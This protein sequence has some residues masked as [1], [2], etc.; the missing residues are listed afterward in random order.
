M[1]RRF[2][3]GEPEPRRPDDV[4]R[5]GP[6]EDPADFK[7]EEAHERRILSWSP[8]PDEDLGPEIDEPADDDPRLED[9]RLEDPR[10]KDEVREQARAVAEPRAE[11]LPA[12][13]VEPRAADEAP[14]PGA[15]SLA[16]PPL[17]LRSAARDAAPAE[18]RVAAAQ[19]DQGP[20][21]RGRPRGRPRRQVHFHVD[22][23]EELLLLAAA[24]AHGSQQKGLVAALQALQDNE[25]LRDE[26]ERLRTEC[27]RQRV[28]LAEAEAIFNR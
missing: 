6:A 14:R 23:D 22:P 28:L 20:R 12:P 19:P 16:A 15:S 10:L 1:A 26:I 17:E 18:T 21:R 2:N 5:G 8:D 24:R 3:R 4:N 9:P 25:I 11:V 7:I 13:P 27:E